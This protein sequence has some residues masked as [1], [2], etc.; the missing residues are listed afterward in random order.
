MTNEI[1]NDNVNAQEDVA[2]LK[3]LQPE[4][5]KMTQRK[6]IFMITVAG[7][8]GAFSSYF[9]VLAVNLYAPG[10]A[11]IASVISYSLNDILWLNGVEWT[12]RV[13]A[14]NIIFW[15]LYFIFNL[16][17]IYLSVRWFSKR[18]LYYSIYGLMVNLFVSML[19]A[20]IPG[21]SSGLIDLQALADVEGAGDSLVYIVTFLFA[22]IGGITSG[23]SVGL[24][25][26][27]GACSMGL[28][29]IVKYVSREKNIN[30]SP[31]IM[32]IAAISIT[33]FVIIRASI[34]ELQGYDDAGNPIIGPAP[35]TQ[36]FLGSTFIS[37]VYIGS[38]LF[39]VT[40]SQTVDKIFSSAKKVQII[41]TSE[42]TDEISDYLNQESYHR[43][44]T[45]LS[46][47]GGYSKLEKK[48][49]KMI[50]NY[51]EMYDVV[52]KIAAID[53]KAF[54]TV[55]EIF[56]V[57]DIHDWTTI[58]DED[59]ER[60]RQRLVKKQLKTTQVEETN[61]ISEKLDLD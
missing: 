49:I 17:I 14:D 26:K 58:T 31:V 29:P 41:A 51:Q 4:K 55:T 52:E 42:K 24:M 39:I 38:W 19:F 59:K 47:K 35:I 11:G 6:A 61:E 33:I 48:A 23:L 7:I 57:Y 53:S 34:P 21:T 36:N 2:H 9:F 60:E 56:K 10:I 18:F 1:K 37:P 27:V 40:Y 8:I 32:T 46:Q 45:I 43:S 13:A 54:I 25:F 5:I 12:A 28:D 50:A 15:T 20:A 44:H 30:L 22:F 3:M 16:P